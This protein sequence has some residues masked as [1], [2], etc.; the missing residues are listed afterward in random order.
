MNL[1]QLG[2]K[3][4]TD[5]VNSSH[6]H[7]NQ[8]YCHIYQRYFNEIRMEVKTFIEI[9]VLQGR[10]LLMW[11]EYFPNATIYGIDI[12]PN[13]KSFERG[14]V[15]ILVGDQNNPDFLKKVEDIGE[16]D[17]LLDDGSHIIRHQINSFNTLF[18][19]CKSY[20]IIEDLRCS[21]EELHNRH[22]HRKIWS[23]AKFN[24]PSDDLKNY[25]K[26]MN[27]FLFDNIKQL[28]LHKTK[29]LFSIHFYP[30]IIIFEN[31]K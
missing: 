23:G 15:K 4:K 6:T 1:A 26:D 21:Y 30:M 13:V 20:Y 18:K 17:I 25:R 8:N 2:H 5:K 3:Y 27:N 28:D 16:Y 10:S 7:L 29:K 22:D 9:G 12:N 11:E 14:R 19:N 24:D 31:I